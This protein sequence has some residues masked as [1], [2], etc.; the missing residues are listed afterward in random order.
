VEEEL[1]QCKEQLATTLAA[2]TKLEAQ[3]KGIIIGCNI[4]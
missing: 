2:A 4:E 1:K 3:L